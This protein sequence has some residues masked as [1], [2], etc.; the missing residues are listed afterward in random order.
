MKK[1]TLQ[2]FNYRL[3]Q[4]AKKSVQQHKEFRY[5]SNKENRI[6]YLKSI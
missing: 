3:K 1:E 4:L 2:E 5:I 6:V